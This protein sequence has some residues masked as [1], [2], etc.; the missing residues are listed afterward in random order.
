MESRSQPAQPG[1]DPFG[2]D[3]KYID[4]L[5]KTL[6]KF[7]YTRY[8]RVETL[9]LEHIPREGGA[10]LVGTHRG[11]IPWD[12]IMVLHAIVQ[13]TGRV[14]RFLTH[15]GLLKF[16]PVSTVMARLGGVLA[17]RQSADW[18]L[19]RN[20]MLG[21][22]P[23]GVRS[24]FSLY[25]QAY[26]LQS[27]GRD[28][29]VKMALRHAAPIVPFV[30]VGSA[31]SLPV[32]A[33]IRSRRWTRFSLWPC[34]PVSTFPF[35]PL[36]L[37]SKWHTQF[38]PAMHVERQHPPEAARDAALVKTISRE[39]KEQMQAA[40]DGILRRRRSIFFGSVFGAGR[41]PQG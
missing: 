8:W 26:K 3:R 21:V 32:F 6:F 16:R 28:D 1:L 14:P 23:E 29:F 7:L 2:M 12:A 24:A 5:G 9:G 4:R 41:D 22:F 36:P 38:L 27:F 40:V 37:P 33:Q 39:V 15:P 13:E 10:V 11:F 30:T 17:C 18:V 31:E 25:R 34:I 35:I 19:A 20:E